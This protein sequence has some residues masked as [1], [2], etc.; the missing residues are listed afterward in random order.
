MTLFFTA[1]THFGHWSTPDRNIIKYCNRPFDRISE[2]DMALIENWN[3]V[4]GPKDTI[5]HLGDFSFYR[6]MKINDAI[7]DSLNG[8]KIL[9]VGNHDRDKIQKNSHWSAVHQYLELKDKRAGT[10]LVMFHYPL[11]SWN[12]SYHGSWDLHGHTHGNH[13]AGNWADGKPKLS[14]DV[15]VDTHEFTPWNFEQ[16]RDHM[17]SLS[18]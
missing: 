15:G 14:L 17:K 6:D 9:I 13:P 2:M 8:K 4:V 5:Y 7:L 10:W 1:D 12:G 11:A 16:I 3:S 18:S